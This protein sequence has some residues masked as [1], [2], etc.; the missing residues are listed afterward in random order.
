MSEGEKG[1]TLKGWERRERKSILSR[2][3]GRIR[4]EPLGERVS[5]SI[6]R[7]RTLL[8]KMNE[9]VSKLQHREKDLFQKCVRAQEMKDP[10]TAAIYANEC[11]QVRKIV[12][13]TLGSQLALEQVVTRL[14]T[15]KNFGDLA[16]N[17]GPVT[18]VV[19]SLRDKLV[20]IV[21]EMAYGLEKVG[22]TL[23]ELV[24]SVGETTGQTINLEA[25]SPEAQRILDEA[26]E[27]AEQ[28]MKERFP[29]L[30]GIPTAEKKTKPI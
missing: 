1:L 24:M 30:P 3:R 28:R 5:K 10:A 2:I 7:L 6:Y 14:E 15:V 22:E 18:N 27:L 19:H 21:P 13:T 8:R 29:V 25:A 11:A 16:S 12:K 4:P 26:T 9:S 20:G 17:I 23:D